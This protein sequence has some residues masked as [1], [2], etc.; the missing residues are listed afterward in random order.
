MCFPLWD[1]Y[2]DGGRITDIFSSCSRQIRNIL[3]VYDGDA[4]F[5]LKRKIALLKGRRLNH[6]FYVKNKRTAREAPRA[7]G[8]IIQLTTKP[9]TIKGNR[10]A[11]VV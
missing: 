8:R 1:S 10:S 11:L 9:F 7:V 2:W 5:V 3:T 4:G 6:Y